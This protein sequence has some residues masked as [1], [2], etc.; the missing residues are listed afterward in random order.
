MRGLAGK[1][2]VVVGGA[3]GIGTAT[4]LRFAEEGS[5][6][7][8]GDLDGA[9][10]NDVAERIR[11]AGGRAVACETDISDEGQVQALVSRA[12]AEYGGIDMLHANAADLS[13]ETIGRDTD[14]VGMPME[15]FDRTVHVGARGHLLCARNAIPELLKRGGGALVFT[16]SGSAFAGEPQRPSYAMA[17]SAVNALVRHI[18]SRWGKEGIRANAVAP[19]LVRTERNFDVLEDQN[20]LSSILAT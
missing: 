3:G 6:V 1:V 11:A 9:A 13:P 10:A 14:V 8:V 20:V 15:A 4:C 5:A 16:S 12:V 2:A 18:A 19:G 7:A 17:K